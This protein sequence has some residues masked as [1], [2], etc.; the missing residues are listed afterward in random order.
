[1]V[2][3]RNKGNLEKLIALIEARDQGEKLA[4]FVEGLLHGEIVYEDLQEEF[5]EKFEPRGEFDDAL[6]SSDA[7]YFAILEAAISLCR[8]GDNHNASRIF[9]VLS[10]GDETLCWNVKRFVSWSAFSSS[11]TSVFFNEDFARR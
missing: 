2:S 4:D 3:E 9:T 1:M 7:I 10:I 11:K 6:D 5:D 8:S